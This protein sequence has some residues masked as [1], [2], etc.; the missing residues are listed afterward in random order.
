V[1]FPGAAC[2]QPIELQCYK[3]APLQARRASLDAGVWPSATCY[4]S[5]D[6]FEPFL[7]AS[8]L[9]LLPLLDLS[10]FEALLLFEP[11][12][13]ESWSFDQAEP[14]VLPGQ[15]RTYRTSRE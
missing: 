15:T 3:A 5:E 14:V 10:P 11:S 6:F 12:S 4:S 1:T 9:E 8:P 2:C 7:D 13:S